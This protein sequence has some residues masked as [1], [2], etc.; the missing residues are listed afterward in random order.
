MGSGC[1]PTGTSEKLVEQIAMAM[2]RGRFEWFR[3]VKRRDETENIG[4][5][6][7]MKME[8]SALEEDL[9]CDETLSEDT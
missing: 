5:V 7:K 3:H 2:R 8:G 6:T 9:G 1:E 4:E